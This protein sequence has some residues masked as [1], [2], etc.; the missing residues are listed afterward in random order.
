[1]SLVAEKPLFIDGKSQHDSG[2]VVEARRGPGLW[3]YTSL[4]VVGLL[5]LDVFGGLSYAT[6]AALLAV[7]GFTVLYL[8]GDSLRRAALF[9]SMID[10]ADLLMI[11]AVY[12]SVV[13]LYRV[14]FVLVEGSDLL[15][16]L[17][18][19]S[20]LIVGVAGPLVYTV[21]IRRRSLATLGLSMG[22]LPIVAT[23]A[24]LFA[25]VQFSITFWGYGDLPAT[26]DV[27][28][29]LGMTL[30]VGIFEAVFFRGFV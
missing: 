18:F 8:T 19:A 23:L 2:R 29:P 27:V 3:V 9:H 15:L 13:A 10:R 20:G 17:F 4:V 25:A 22:N 21:W 1:M 7:G 16:F 12:A 24:L 28:T 14:A 5:L 11:V 26:K 30:M 6:A